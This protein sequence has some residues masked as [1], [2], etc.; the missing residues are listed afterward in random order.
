M[1]CRHFERVLSGLSFFCGDATYSPCYRGPRG[2][3]FCACNKTASLIEYRPFAT[4]T[5]RPALVVPDRLI[6]YRDD[7]YSVDTL[8]AEGGL[9]S[10]SVAV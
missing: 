7:A 9:Y 2:S 6:Q 8:S 1:L 5:D 3:F 4:L 10:I